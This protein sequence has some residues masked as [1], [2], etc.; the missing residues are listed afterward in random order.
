ME[1]KKDYD[2]KTE[3]Q[4]KEV[5]KPSAKSVK[6]EIEK[7]KPLETIVYCGPTIKGVIQ[8]YAHFTQGIPKSLKEYLAANKAANRLLVPLDKFVETKKNIQANGTVEN[9][10]YNKILKGE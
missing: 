2:I 3:E 1:E 7:D 10:T 5:K 8:Q 4:E 6:K 9:L